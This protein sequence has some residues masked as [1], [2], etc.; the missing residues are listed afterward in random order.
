MTGTWIDLVLTGNGI[1][2]FSPFESYE[3]NQAMSRKALA[4]K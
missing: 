1:D 4:F 3:A 2:Q